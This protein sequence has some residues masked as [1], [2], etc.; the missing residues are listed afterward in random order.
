VSLDGVPEETGRRR[1]MED[2]VL[3][4]VEGTIDS[5]PPQR[6]R[7]PEVVREAVRRSVRSAV[8]EHWG[9]KPIAKVHV[10]VVDVR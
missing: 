6:R 7:D 8:D 1:A 10:S 5:I 2:V 3:D 9:K 4:A